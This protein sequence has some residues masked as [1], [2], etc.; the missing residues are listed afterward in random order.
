MTGQLIGMERTLAAHR[1]ECEEVIELLAQSGQV[2]GTRALERLRVRV[3]EGLARIVSV[4]GELQHRARAKLAP[5][6]SPYRIWWV[7]DKSLQQATPWQVARMKAT[8]FDD[9]PVHDLCCGIGG[10][11]IQLAAR[12][13]LTAVDLDPVTAAMAGANL[14]LAG[15][16]RSQQV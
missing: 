1:A 15:F 6:D 16:P 8:W 13:E 14:D 3:G 2:E 9:A 4:A 7:G 10:D 12:G 5:P 11:S